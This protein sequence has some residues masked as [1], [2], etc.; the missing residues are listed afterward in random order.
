MLADAENCAHAVEKLHGMPAR[1]IESA[2]VHEAYGKQTIW[3]GEVHTF[4]LS[5]PSG[6]QRCYAWNETD[7]GPVTTVLAAGP[8]NSARTA[9][10][11]A[12][13]HRIR[14]QRRL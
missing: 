11:A 10:Q 14:D 4:E 3:Q 12:L 5:T 9:V 2:T 6:D 1:L 8:I 7:E 13:V